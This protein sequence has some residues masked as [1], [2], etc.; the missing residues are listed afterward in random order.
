LIQ[1]NIIRLGNDFA[2]RVNAMVW[3]IAPICSGH[4]F[5]WAAFAAFFVAIPLFAAPNAIISVNLTWKRS[6]LR[7]GLPWNATA[8]A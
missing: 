6:R 8:M 4:T 5:T 2:S 1:W 7:I 3:Q